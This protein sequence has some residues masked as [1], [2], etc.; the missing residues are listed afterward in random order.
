MRQAVWV[1]APLELLALVQGGRNKARLNTAGVIK[2][3]FQLAFVY[4]GQIGLRGDAMQ[5]THLG[6]TAGLVPT[7]RF[8]SSVTHRGQSQAGDGLR[9]ENTGA[10]QALRISAVSSF[11]SQL[12]CRAT[13]SH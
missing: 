2:C 8:S 10:G 11:N 5:A 12:A 4:T 3:G 6:L 13:K 7:A 1:P 9:P